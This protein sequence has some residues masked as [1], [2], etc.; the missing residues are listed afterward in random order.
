MNG[1]EQL[2][3]GSDTELAALANEC[4]REAGSDIVRAVDLMIE[5]VQRNEP[6]HRRLLD[7]LTRE[8]C[9]DWLNRSY[10]DAQQNR[11]PLQRVSPAEVEARIRARA[12]VTR[13]F[14]E[15]LRTRR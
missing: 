4:R 15:A 12:E 1:S 8:A 7:P 2:T 13:Q 6:L 5:R 10:A 3:D 9:R 14:T 11:A